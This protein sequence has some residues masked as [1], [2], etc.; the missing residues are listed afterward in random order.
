MVAGDC[1][2]WVLKGTE[3]RS[4]V[5]AHRN[6]RCTKAVRAALLKSTPVLWNAILGRTLF[7]PVT[8]ASGTAPE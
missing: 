3:W 8:Q 5:S 6:E 1:H 4:G 7:Y 2:G